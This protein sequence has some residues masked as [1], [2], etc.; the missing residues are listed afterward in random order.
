MNIP[1][2]VRLLVLTRDAWTCQVCGR[3]LAHA[4]LDGDYSLQ[5]RRARG[6]GG[7]KR[8]DTNGPANLITVCGSA[9]TG[10]H[11]RIE[12]QPDWAAGRGLR[13]RQNQTPAGCPVLTVGGWLL[14]HPDGT[15]AP[16][17]SDR[18]HLTEPAPLSEVIADVALRL[19][20]PEEIA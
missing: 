13:L 14:L 3:N 16:A 1:K 18:P 10:C 2:R 15:T 12:S 7:S 17:Q 20:P 4:Y 11:Q 5:H 19:H 6:M 8:P 9:T